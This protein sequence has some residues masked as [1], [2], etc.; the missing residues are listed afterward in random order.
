MR[1]HLL[2]VKSHVKRFRI[3]LISLTNSAGEDAGMTQIVSINGKWM[4]LVPDARTQVVPASYQLWVVF[5][6]QDLPAFSRAI[7]HP[8]PAKTE[9]SGQVH[10]LTSARLGWS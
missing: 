10:T 3:V 8:S 5:A 6:G 9:R 2:E 4:I 1:Y 7:L